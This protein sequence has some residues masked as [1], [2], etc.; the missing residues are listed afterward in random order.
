MEFG[1][2]HA[3]DRAFVWIIF[4]LW[5]PIYCSGVCL[6]I[7]IGIIFGV[8]YAVAI[9]FGALVCGMTTI[10]ENAKEILLGDPT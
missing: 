6:T 7:F 8:T 5:F 1:Y 2:K 10:L 3:M 9:A 4:L